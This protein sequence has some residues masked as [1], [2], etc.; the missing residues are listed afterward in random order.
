MLD[1]NDFQVAPEQVAQD[2]T[3][4][5]FATNNNPQP[6]PQQN[7]PVALDFDSLGGPSIPMGTQSQNVK[8]DSEEE[9]R[10]LKRQEEAEMRRQKISKKIE[11]EERMR[12]E[13]RA[14]A[15]EYLVEFEQKRQEDIAKKRQKL[16][17]ARNNGNSN[18]DG[19]QGTADSWAK[20]NDNID[21]KD[22]EYKGTKDVQR[23]REAMMHRKE[24]P[25]GEP[26]KN[27]FG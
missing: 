27:F 2:T 17:E 13:I 4:D 10:L 6:E 1:F 19:G 22:S 12:Q 18:Q 7:M 5:P 11:E 20:V 26:L 14:K 16:E 15:R 24:D 8:V 3:D 25:N 9:Q 21:L 23:M